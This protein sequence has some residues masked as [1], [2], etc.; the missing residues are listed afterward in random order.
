MSPICVR[1]STAPARDQSNTVRRQ[2]RLPRS[3]PRKRESRCRKLRALGLWIRVPAFAGTSGRQGSHLALSKKLLR[4]LDHPFVDH[5]RDVEIVLLD[6][7][8][9]AVAKNALV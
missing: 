9:V 3:F 1:F 8:H 7:H 6:H 4:I 5:M 2:R